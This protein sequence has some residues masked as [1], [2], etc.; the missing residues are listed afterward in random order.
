MKSLI[1]RIALVGAG[2]VGKTTLSKMFTDI[3]FKLNPSVS[4]DFFAQRGVTNEAHLHS[5]GPEFIEDFQK[6]MRQYFRIQYDFWLI[7]HTKNLLPIIS[8][9]S[10]IDHL[11]YEIYLRKD[12]PLPELA[13]LVENTFLYIQNTIDGDSP[14]YTHLVFL[15]YPQDFMFNHDTGDGFRL[16]NHGKN[17]AVSSIMYRLL[18][19][20][21]ETHAHPHV[22]MCE[23]TT[24]RDKFIHILRELGNDYQV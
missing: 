12:I 6:G 10:P 2:G 22:I 21:K 24:P 4:R 11:G 18:M 5:Y 16:V 13:D 3:G 9:R 14:R 8:E 17:F 23:G 19:S 15:D 7:H 1:P 20:F